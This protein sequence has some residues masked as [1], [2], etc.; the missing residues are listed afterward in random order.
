MK[1]PAPARNA[2]TLVFA[3]GSGAS[4]LERT[5]LAVL[6]TRVKAFII[7]AA[8][9]C[10]CQGAAAQQLSVRA[11]KRTRP[12]HSA[13]RAVRPIA[14]PQQVA[15]PQE[16]FASRPEK[17]P[18]IPVQPSDCDVQVAKVAVARLLGR[19]VA[20]GECGAPDALE[21]ESV[22]MP[23]ATRVA[24]TPP[25]T[26]RCTMALEVAQWVREDV[27]PAAAKLGAPLR[28][29]ENLGSFE[30]RGRDRVRGATLSEHGRANA[31]DVRSFKLANGKLIVLADPKAPKDFRDAVRLS[32]CA[33]FMTVLG[34]GSDSDH[35]EHVHIDLAPRRNNFKL[36]EWD[37]REPAMQAQ[38]P[39]AAAAIPIDEVP[40]PRPRPRAAGVSLRLK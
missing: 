7:L 23:D 17:E 36:C 2:N 3:Q 21:V 37:V 1:L 4:A 13:A 20:P 35:A 27:A 18:A 30:C 39:V 19:L 9:L 14:I 26:L 16:A 38:S 5:R 33:R 11:A 22:I 34:P 25:A 28:G 24:I 6:S 29:L 15:P 40:L 10:A 32:A 8:L 31:L 12:A